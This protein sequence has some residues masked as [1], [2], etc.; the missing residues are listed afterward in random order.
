[1]KQ[2]VFLNTKREGYGVEQ[3]GHTLTVK[4]MIEILQAYEEDTPIYFCND[5]GYT[6]GSIKEYDIEDGYEELGE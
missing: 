3:C 5:N 1:M 4:E 2:I 6:Y